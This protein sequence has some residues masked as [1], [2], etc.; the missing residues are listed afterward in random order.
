MIIQ[1]HTLFVDGFND[2]IIGTTDFGCVVYSKKIMVE[3]LIFTG[4][5][6]VDAIQ[7]CEYNI[8]N[9][10]VG[11]CSPIFV[12]DFDSDLNEIEEIFNA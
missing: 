3:K 8:W 7:H 1:D 5:T 12:N 9:S 2:A 11:E 6:Y 10:Y 4:A